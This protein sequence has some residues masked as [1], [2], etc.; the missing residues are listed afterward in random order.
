MERVEHN[1]TLDD[2]IKENEKLR[3]KLAD[4]RARQ[5]HLEE[6]GKDLAAARQEKKNLEETA[7]TLE[8]QKNQ[9]GAELAIVRRTKKEL[10]EQIKTLG[11]ARARDDERARVHEELGEVR[12][13]VGPLLDRSA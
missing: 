9:A 1:E 4:E 12:G 11:N 3:A 2:V 6:T 5:D 8:Q 13:V 10:E 7:G